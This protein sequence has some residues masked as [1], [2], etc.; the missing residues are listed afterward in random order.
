MIDGF[1]ETEPAT[2]ANIQA[3]L[4]AASAGDEGAAHKLANALGTGRL[5]RARIGA[6][7]KTD[8]D[9]LWQLV[10]NRLAAAQ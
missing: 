6:L 2:L 5:D 3:C 8:K 10:A 4:D 9:T 1:Q 7:S